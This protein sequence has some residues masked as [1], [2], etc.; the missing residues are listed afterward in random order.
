M[1]LGNVHAFNLGIDG[2]SGFAIAAVERSGCRH[3][4]HAWVVTLHCLSQDFNR[5]VGEAAHGFNSSGIL[6][7]PPGLPLRPFVQRPALALLSSLSAMPGT[8]FEV[9]DI[10]LF[11]GRP[12][13]QTGYYQTG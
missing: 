4:T 10:A 5:L 11:S 13:Q 8:C 2:L 7:R 1:G 12:L 9:P 3:D 6:G